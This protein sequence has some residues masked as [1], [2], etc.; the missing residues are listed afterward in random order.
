MG[1][2]EEKN[3]SFA[4]LSEKAFSGIHLK[5]TTSVKTSPIDIASAAAVILKAWLGHIKSEM[6]PVMEK[7]FV[8]DLDPE[9]SDISQAKKDSFG[10]FRDEIEV[11]RLTLRLRMTLTMI[12]ISRYVS[13]FVVNWLMNKLVDVF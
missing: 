4:N 7:S 10:E 8:L 3:F 13:Y 12:S 6:E 11:K 1:K 2:V 9:K 5:T